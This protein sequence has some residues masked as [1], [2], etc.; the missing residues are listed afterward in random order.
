[1]R[2]PERGSLTSSGRGSWRHSIA[3]TKPFRSSTRALPPRSRIVRTGLCACSRPQEPGSTCKW[4]IWRRP[5]SR[6]EGRFV[7]DEAHLIAGT[8]HAPAL[9]ALGKLKIHLA[10]ETGALEVAEIAK[11]MLQSDTPFV[12]H[13]AMWY[14]ARH[15]L[16]QGDPMGAHVWLCS[17]GFEER[18]RLFPLYPHEVT[19]DAEMVRIAAAVGDEDLANHAISLAT[20][21]SERNPGVLSC[22][23]AVAHCRGIWADSVNDLR[24]A[25]S[26]YRRGPAPSRLCIGS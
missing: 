4:V 24:L 23:A 10:D 9:V 15:S 20:R 18:L 8:L 1:M 19:D 14:L 2:T 16:S 5:R 3:S 25:A 12:R 17:Q 11:V 7:L 13:H 6:L 26:I 21:R 22:R